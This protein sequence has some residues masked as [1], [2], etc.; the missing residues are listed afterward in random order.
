MKAIRFERYGAPDV[1]ALDDVD[2]PHP[3]AAQIRIRV[4]AAGVNGPD[5]KIRAG[6]HVHVGRRRAGAQRS[7]SCRGT[8]DRHL[9]RRT[10]RGVSSEQRTK[11]DAIVLRRRGL[12]RHRPRGV[13]A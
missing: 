5:W 9:V 1:L 4:R 7:R 3:R 2:E 8:N 11:V 10:G 13:T 12:P 6:D